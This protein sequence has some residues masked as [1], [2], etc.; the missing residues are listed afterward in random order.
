MIHQILSESTFNR[1]LPH[2]MRAAIEGGIGAIRRRLPG[3]LVRLRRL[4][5][6]S[7]PFPGALWVALAT[8]LLCGMFL[9]AAVY[10]FAAGIG[11]LLAVAFVV[12]W[13]VLKGLRCRARFTTRHAVERGPLSLVLRVDNRWP[14]AIRGVELLASDLAGDGCSTPL[15]P[16]AARVD[17]RLTIT[18]PAHRRGIYP[19]LP[20]RV[21]SA[22][23]LGIQ[24]FARTIGCSGCVRVRPLLVDLPSPLRRL[25]PTSLQESASVS[26]T[27]GAEGEW[28]GVRPYR[29][30]ESIRH[31]HWPS[32]A[33]QDRLM[34]LQ[35][36][37]PRA[38]EVSLVLDI[39]ASALD[40]DPWKCPGEWAVR[41]AASLGKSFLDRG[42]TVR[43]SVG[44][45]G[46]SVLPES[47][48]WEQ[49][50]DLLAELDLASLPRPR[51]AGHGHLWTC[52]VHT[53][54]P[55]RQEMCRADAAVLV[56]RDTSLVESPTG[57]T[58]VLSVDELR[59]D[60]ST[61]E[62]LVP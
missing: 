54:A 43:F 15:P 47:R 41:V 20:L 38:R 28:L 57:H 13:L 46:W 12:P 49:L 45:Q 50:L 29:D 59:T 17:N 36:G 44:D 58:L 26:T 7:F 35:R 42:W 25:G 10:W 62:P 61:R 56:T 48:S 23:P 30:G 34:V 40:T 33:R 22:H 18:V 11:L 4:L 53:R 1:W 21:A 9:V 37:T 6:D 27:P 52:I 31:V 3:L 32:S 60:L 51:V 55:I 16:L 2:R 5:R 8:S 19:T 24:R 39:H 14:V